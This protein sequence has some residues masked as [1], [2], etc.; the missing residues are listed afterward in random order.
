M[1]NVTLNTCHCWFV[2]Y[3]AGY[4]DSDPDRQRN[5]DL[6][7]EHTTRVC[8]EIRA[9]GRRLGLADDDINT[10][11]AA[12]LFH[13]IGRFEQFRRFGTY[14]DRLSVDHG[15]LGAS[16]LE[17]E[18]A[19]DTV[20]ADLRELIIKTTRYHNRLQLP[21]GETP[22]CAFFTRLLRDADKLD[23]WRVV[24]DYHTNKR[25]G[26]EVNRTI[27]LELPDG[28]DISDDV[29]RS[30]MRDRFVDF[31]LLKNQNDFKIAQIGW[32]YDIN[33]TPTIEEIMKRRY[34]T[35]VRSFLPHTPKTEAV[36]SAALGYLLKKTGADDDPMGGRI[37]E[38]P[39]SRWR[40]GR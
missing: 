35:T 40:Q 4:R 37:S 9:I 19:L 16:I 7:V 15:D 29:Y 26:G 6:K 10:A 13:D 14:N 38:N 39:V 22:R 20:D 21:E 23:I 30:L 17:Q 1:D 28:E 2:S 31:S 11:E 24:I 34:I 8:T 25:N 3:T 32:I 33:F 5:I 36:I 12:A 27:E 18:N